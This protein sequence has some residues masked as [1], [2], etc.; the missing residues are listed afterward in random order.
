MLSK[1]WEAT[2]LLGDAIEKGETDEV[3]IDVD[4]EDHQCPEECEL[5]LRFG[6]PC[7]HWMYTAFIHDSPLQLSLI[8]PRWLLDGPEKVLDWTMSGEPPTEAEIME[9]QTVGTVKEISK[10]PDRH[11]GDEFRNH[12]QNLIMTTAIPAIEEQG[13]LDGP[14]AKAFA[15]AFQ[16]ATD[17]ITA[18]AIERE[19]PATLK[20]T[21]V[22]VFP[23]SHRR[24]Q[25]GMTG[26]EIQGAKEADERRAI[27]TAAHEAQM[28]RRYQE[29]K[30]KEL[31]ERQ[32]RKAQC[33]AEINKQYEDALAALETSSPPPPSIQR[34]I[35]IRSSPSSQSASE[36][37]S[38]PGESQ[39]KPL[40]IGSSPPRDNG[41]CGGEDDN[42]DYGGEDDHSNCG[43]EESDNDGFLNAL[44]DFEP[45]FHLCLHPSVRTIS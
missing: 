18:T 3:Y 17:H 5:P 10:H 42:S 2:K 31:D 6:L 37:P 29:E 45:P 39:D 7:R 33:L 28:E 30:E 19:L 22:K 35:P 1:E 26:R 8:D 12:G 25:R 20:T 14:Q 24:R 41:E 40:E 16:K 43:G 32:R 13:K 27:H 15:Q 9:M 11:A 38:Q 4:N 36:R 23:N 21:K 34:S 44:N